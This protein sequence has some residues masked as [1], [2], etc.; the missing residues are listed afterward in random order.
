M[1]NA[2]NDDFYSSDIVRILG[3]IQTGYEAAVR[4]LTEDANCRLGLMRKP[5]GE[6]LGRFEPDGSFVPHG[7][8]APQP[9]DE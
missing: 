6:P 8:R 1:P 2:P 3:E 9:R 4:L 7:S 5:S